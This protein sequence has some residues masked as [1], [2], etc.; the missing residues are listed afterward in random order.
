MS[1]ANT[2]TLAPRSLVL[3][4]EYFTESGRQCELLKVQ[5]VL[6][7]PGITVIEIMQRVHELYQESATRQREIQAQIEQEGAN[8][9]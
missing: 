6:S 3:D 4:R 2:L 9:D 5:A 7:E 1:N 8:N